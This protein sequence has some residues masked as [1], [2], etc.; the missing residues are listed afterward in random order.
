MSVCPGDHGAAGC[1][2]WCR[3]CALVIRSALRGLPQGYAALSGVGA[4]RCSPTD[5]V[6]VSG[7]RERRSPSPAVDLR[8]ELFRAV[9]VWSGDLRSYLGHVPG[10]GGER[11][12]V[13]AAEV[14]YLNS[15][16]ERMI[17]RAD[18]ARAFGVQMRSLFGTVL[19]LVKNGPLRSHLIIPCPYCDMRTLFQQEGVAGRPW[20]TS[21]ETVLGG[22][23]RLFTETEMVWMTEIRLVI[24]R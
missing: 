24:K 11:E 12:V 3:G 5:V 2:V 8:D 16:F 13:L 14:D 17:V 19:G 7:S 18:A 21:C 9:C 15:H 6:R 20:Y 10:R 22:C 1:P 4:F 23:G